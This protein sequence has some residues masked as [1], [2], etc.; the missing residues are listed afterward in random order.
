MTTAL[1]VAVLLLLRVGRA[2]WEPSRGIA[3]GCADRA[4]MNPRRQFENESDVCSSVT[5]KKFYEST[6]HH[7][8]SHRLKVEPFV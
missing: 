7:K 8:K 3:E 4:A 5:E 1:N 6:R 2:R